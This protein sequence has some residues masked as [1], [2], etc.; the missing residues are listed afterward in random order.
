MEAWNEKLAFASYLVDPKH[1]KEWNRE[2]GS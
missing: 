2:E 1:N